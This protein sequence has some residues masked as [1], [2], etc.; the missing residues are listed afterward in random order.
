M[1]PMDSVVLENERE[2]RELATVHGDSTELSHTAAI[3]FLHQSQGQTQGQ[4]Q[5]QAQSHSNSDPKTIYN[6]FGDNLKLCSSGNVQVNQTLNFTYEQNKVTEVEDNKNG[7]MNKLEMLEL[8]GTGSGSMAAQRVS[9]P[10]LEELKS[11]E[12][13]NTYTDD[14]L[15]TLSG[16]TGSRMTGTAQPNVPLEMERLDTPRKLPSGQSDE[17]I[18]LSENESAR[19]GFEISDSHAEHPAETSNE[20]GIETSGNRS[21]TPTCEVNPA[22]SGNRP[23]G[24]IQIKKARHVEIDNSVYIETDASPADIFPHINQSDVTVEGSEHVKINKKIHFKKPASAKNSTPES[25][26]NA[27]APSAEGGTT[28]LNTMPGGTVRQSNTVRNVAENDEML[29]SV[30]ALLA[31]PTH[32]PPKTARPSSKPAT[33][34]GKPRQCHESPSPSENSC[35]CERCCSN[36]KELE[37][38]SEL[39]YRCQHCSLPSSNYKPCPCSSL[40]QN[41]LPENEGRNDVRDSTGELCSGTCCLL[42]DVGASTCTNNELAGTEDLHSNLNGLEY[43]WDWDLSSLQ[44]EESSDTEK[45]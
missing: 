17:G 21:G 42:E 11:C 5:G 1:A 38:S 23:S 18:N 35:T 19:R 2:G 25:N 15:H 37:S 13:N 7:H 43:R 16:L 22:A 28:V 40:S 39:S 26:I 29:S 8:N 34:K 4:T 41:G 6:I 32:Y 31:A 45:D 24:H 12:D 33:T 36:T 10:E 14:Q 20:S 30:S 9:N 3:P 44:S 27:A